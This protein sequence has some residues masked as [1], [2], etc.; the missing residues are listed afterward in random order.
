MAG[1][2]VFFEGSA[3]SVGEGESVLETLIRGGANVTFSC[4]KGTCQSCMLETVR[5]EPGEG[6]AKGL[7]S[8]LVDA[9]MFLPCCAHPTRDLEVRRPDPAKLFTRLQLAEKEWLSPSVC[10][11]SFEPETNLDWKAGQFVNLR[12]SDG[13]V[14]SYSIAS[15]PEEDYFLTVHVKRIEGGVMST[16]LCDELEIGDAIDAQGPIGSCYYDPA[17]S[18]KNLL[19]LCT[20]SG[21]SPLYGIVRDAL[22]QGHTGEIHLFHASK[23]ADGLYLRDELRAL[24][25]EHAQLRYTASLTQPADLPEGVV[26]GRVVARAFERGPD[27]A[28]WMVYLC[29]IPEMVYEG[30]HQAVLA[31]AARADIRADP[32][33]YAHP[34]QP[35]DSRKLAQIAPDPE[36][37]EALERGPGLMRILTSFY[38]AA[39][40][41]PRLAP[42]FHRVTKQRAIEQQYAFLADLFSGRRAYF[43]LRPFNAHHWMIISDEL[44]DY[45][46]A[47][48]EAVLRAYGLSEPLI[49][50]W[51]AV[52]ELFR[53]EIVKSS[54]RGM[55][56]AGVEQPMAPPE[57]V[58]VE[59]PC[60]C[61]GCEAEM[62]VGETARYH[63]HGGQLFCEA[64]A[65]VPSRSRPPPSI[66]P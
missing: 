33:E 13:V 12:R 2:R 60:V 63:A 29:G 50:R 27:L 58:V 48:M 34:Y 26:E 55:I 17:D 36:L 3:Y 45:R 62:N 7:R 5:G 32:F 41:D 46:E 37:W 24:A 10:R 57:R 8:A 28:G 31:G 39:F 18:A 6:A 11:L 53:R 40:V 65:G 47:A 54:A 43:G 44:F 20:G 35:D 64:C 22:R 51:A 56:I 38:D 14:R 4:R 59:L 9:G 61:D 49:R 23:T 21:L 19:L 16:W 42:F 52:H 1:V 66:S 30:R 25:R 15:I